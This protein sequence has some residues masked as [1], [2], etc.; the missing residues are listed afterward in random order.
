MISQD[1]AEKTD[2]THGKTWPTS[3]GVRSFVSPM[4]AMASAVGHAVLS[5]SRERLS[6]WRRPRVE[7]QR[8]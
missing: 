8:K 1:Q 5:A 6:S 4:L 7:R 3:S 2:T